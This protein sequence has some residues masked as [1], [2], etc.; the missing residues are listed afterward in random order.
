MYAE[1]DTE[2]TAGMSGAAASARRKS[3]VRRL[4]FVVVCTLVLAYVVICAF[5]YVYQYH[6]IYL[7]SGWID[8]TPASAGLQYEDVQ[9]QAAD[10][11]SISAWHILRPD[12][13]GTLILCH[14]NGGNMTDRISVARAFHEM[15]LSVL[16]FDYRGYGTSEGSPDETGTYAALASSFNAFSCSSVN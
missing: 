5:M 6:L 4:A 3:G 14:G 1:G 15:G 13:Q 12:D 8:R 11:V 9:L 10:G 16:M 2:E 7:P